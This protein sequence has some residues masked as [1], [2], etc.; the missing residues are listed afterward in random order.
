MKVIISF[1]PLKTEKGYAA[2]G[3]NRQFQ[4]FKAPTYIY[5][6]VPVTAATMFKEAGLDVSW[7]DCIAEGIDYDDFLSIIRQE[8]LDIIAFEVKTPVVKY[9]GTVVDD[10]KRINSLIKAVLFSDHVDALAGESFQNSNEKNK[11][12]R[13]V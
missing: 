7:L 5:P 6:V 1:P 9:M 10:I 8:S 12:F 4:Y 3:Q 13:G 11:I 2:L